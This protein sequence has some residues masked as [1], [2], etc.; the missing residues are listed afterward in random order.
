MIAGEV[1]NVV[2][3]VT[4]LVRVAPTR[5]EQAELCPGILRG[6]GDGRRKV[7]QATRLRNALEL[8]ANPVE[9]I[10]R[11]GSLSLPCC[12]RLQQQEKGADI[13]RCKII[14]H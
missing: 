5:R 9:E 13:G 1:G 2:D 8:A 11:V 14:A 7:R 12:P 4:K 6:P 10:R 3:R